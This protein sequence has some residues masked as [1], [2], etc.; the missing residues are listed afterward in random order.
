MQ[1]ILCTLFLKDE[2]GENAGFELY[3]CAWTPL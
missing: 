1:A 3:R 2:K